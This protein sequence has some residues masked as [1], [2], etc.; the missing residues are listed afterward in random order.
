MS[1]LV[2]QLRHTAAIL[3][4]EAL[5][6][7][8]GRDACTAAADCI[9]TLTN[10]L[11]KAA[12]RIEELEAALRKIAESEARPGTAAYELKQIAARAI[13]DQA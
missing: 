6:L 5:R 1:D 8:S 13:G 9:E 10:R 7:P 3:D 2:Q 4:Q 11:S 12:K